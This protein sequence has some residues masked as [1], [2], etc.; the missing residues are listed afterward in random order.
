[1]KVQNPNYII[2]LILLLSINPKRYSHSNRRK[3]GVRA[4]HQSILKVKEAKSTQKLTI[5]KLA[6][7]AY[8]SESTVKRFLRRKHVDQDYAIAILKAL[9]LEYQNI[10]EDEEDN[11]LV[12]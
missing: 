2:L 3:R 9:N 11:K 1:M 7:K 10:I 12:A 5:E 4:T 6:E 8:I